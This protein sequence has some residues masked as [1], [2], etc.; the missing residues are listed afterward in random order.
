MRRS[1]TLR[2]S[3]AALTLPLLLGGL[4]ACGSDDEAPDPAASSSSATESQDSS[5]TE[6]GEEVDK[7][8]FIDD[9]QA[10]LKA[11]TTAKMTM[12]L[13]M[14]GQAIHADGAVDYST[15]PPQMAMTMESPAMAD[16]SIEMRL[17]DEV[18]YMNMG[19]L[20]NDKFVSYDLSDAANL[21]PGM[22]QLTQTMNPL[23]AFDAFEEGVQAVTFV[24]DEDVDGEQLG[25]YAI[26]VDT[27]KIEQFKDLQTQAELPR[28]ITYDVWLDD[29]NRMRKM[30]FAMPMDAAPVTMEVAFSEWGE[31]VDIAAPPASEI[32]EQP[33]G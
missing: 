29:Q 26:E 10:G 27:S 9:L 3:L 7:T 16:Q 32:A 6:A 2:R 4:A 15:T 8:A 12:H 1:L 22:D 18:L 14:G 30:T 31:T 20:T 17:V 28:T 5:G 13:D 23:A 21:P 19:Q 24:G 11:S 33:T 25:H